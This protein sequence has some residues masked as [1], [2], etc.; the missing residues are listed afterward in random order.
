MS[1]QAQHIANW[2]K[3]WWFAIAFGLGVMGSLITLYFDVQYMRAAVNPATIAEFRVDE[4]ILSTKR[5][6]RWCLGKLLIDGS[7]PTHKAVLE[8]AD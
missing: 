8:C 7:A 3:T 2:F 6:I 1:E 4:A 5:E